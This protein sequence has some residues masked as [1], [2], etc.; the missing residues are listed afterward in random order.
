M[1]YGGG[2]FIKK[3]LGHL[4]VA[5]IGG[6]LY[7]GV[8]L[9][10]RGHTHWTMGVLGGV[11]FALIGLLN[12]WWPDDPIWLQ[13]LQGAVIVTALEFAA[14]LLL[15]IRLGLHIWDYSDM[16]GNVL[17]QICP[18]FAFAWV[19]LSWIAVRLEDLLHAAFKGVRN[20]LEER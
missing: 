14:G 7:M 19:G 13:M 4:P 12:E 11:C 15:N 5:V 18:Q 8:E 1:R 3:L 2:A 9:L 10:W 16:P 17:G 6:L 20:R